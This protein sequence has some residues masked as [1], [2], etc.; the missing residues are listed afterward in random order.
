MYRIAS[1][2]SHATMNIE[3]EI[4]KGSLHIIEQDNTLAHE[5]KLWNLTT[6]RIVKRS[7]FL[8]NLY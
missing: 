8:N 2:E 4:N 7:I 1:F 3:I 6:R 5:D